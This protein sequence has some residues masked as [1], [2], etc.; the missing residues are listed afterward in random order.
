[1][2][3]FLDTVKR[4]KKPMRFSGVAYVNPNSHKVAAIV[5]YTFLGCG[6]VDTATK[7]VVGMQPSDPRLDLYRTYTSY[8]LEMDSDSDYDPE[9]G[10]LIAEELYFKGDLTEK[11]LQEHN[12]H[13]EDYTKPAEEPQVK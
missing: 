2:S 6:Y 4:S 3:E 5:F 8:R 13:A 11:W 10:Y 1:M 12:L 7:K 9:T